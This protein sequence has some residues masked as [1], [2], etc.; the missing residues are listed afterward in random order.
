[1]DHLTD[2]F[3]VRFYREYFNKNTSND[4]KKKKSKMN[5]YKIEKT[6]RGLAR[7]GKVQKKGPIFFSRATNFKI[8]LWTSK[9]R[10]R[11]Y[12]LFLK[13][14]PQFLLMKIVF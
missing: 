1:M 10:F 6:F 12:S 9:D 13:S 2:R 5:S 8:E 7:I 4:M 3:Q 11:S 14:T